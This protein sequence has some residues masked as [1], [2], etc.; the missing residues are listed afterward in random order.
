M[1]FKSKETGF[2]YCEDVM[3]RNTN[4][5]KKMLMSTVI[6]HDQDYIQS[7]QL[8]QMVEVKGCLFQHLADKR[9]VI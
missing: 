4:D 8:L 7:L 9:G 1:E 5:C 2:L 3:N 6:K